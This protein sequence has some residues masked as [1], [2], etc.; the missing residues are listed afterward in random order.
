MNNIWILAA[1]GDDAGAVVGMEENQ[2]TE[3]TIQQD[4]SNGTKTGTEGDTPPG[5]GPMNYVL[6]GLMLVM[7]YFVVIRGP[8]KKQKEHQSMISSLKKNDKIRTIGGIYGTI[9]DV[10]ENEIVLK[11]DESTN[12]KIKIS[13]QAIGTVLGAEEKKK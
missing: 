4:G 10:R 9:M 13:P 1:A 7:V 8:K 2:S 11:I 3:Q 5:I 12:T 6:M